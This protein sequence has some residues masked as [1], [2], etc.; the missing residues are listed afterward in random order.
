MAEQNAKGTTVGQARLDIEP[1]FK[2]DVMPG[3]LLGG[4]SLNSSDS[5]I[6]VTSSGLR[7]G[8]HSDER[9]GMLLHISGEKN[10]VLIPP[11]DSDVDQDTLR[12]LLT[13]RGMSGD[14]RSIYCDQS[15][16]Q[17]LPKVRR[18]QGSLRTGD[19]LFIPQRWLH[20][21]ESSTPT[22]SISLRFGKW[23]EPN[24]GCP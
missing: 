6:F 13:L 23:D 10:F 24:D 14:H 16:N 9:H 2:V 20:D 7:T 15:S 11:E 21:I 22:I 12:E 3:G 8:L 18:I 17:S 19:A 4:H 1:C 5:A